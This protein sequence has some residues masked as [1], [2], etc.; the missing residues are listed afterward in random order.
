MAVD[1]QP[2]L[3]ILPAY[4]PVAFELYIDT[5]TTA[6][7]AENAVVTIL[8]NGAAIT[9]N[10]IRFRS[11]RNEVSPLSVLDTRWY[12]EIDI[13]KYCQDTLAPYVQLSSGFVGPSL[14]FVSNVDMFGVYQIL[15]TYE[16]VDLATGLLEDSGDDQE[17]SDEFSVFAASKGNLESMF[18]DEL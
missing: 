5:L 18:L 8:K 9:T 10:P 13:Q 17:S 4:R 16:V 15:V 12:F 2:P 11:V 1:K 7:R 14:R 6:Y 3:P